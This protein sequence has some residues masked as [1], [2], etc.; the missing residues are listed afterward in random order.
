MGWMRDETGLDKN[1]ANYVPLTPLSHLARAAKVFANREALVYGDLRLTYARY[2][3]RV[4][5]L[6]SALQMAGVAPGDVVATLLPNIPAQAEAHFGVPACGAVL[7]TINIRLDVDTIAYIF[8]HGEAKVVL[9]A[10]K[11]TGSMQ[12]AMDETERRR[13]RQVAHNEKHGIT[14][15]TI[16]RGI[17]DMVGD[18]EAAQKIKDERDS[19]TPSGLK[20]KG[21][22]G[23]MLEAA[24]GSE[25]FTG[26]KMGGNAIAVAA[27]LEKR[28]FQAAENL[29][30]EEA[31]RLRDELV[32]VRG[33]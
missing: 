14:P 3:A 2:H 21:K 11:I 19:Y 30:F 8:D 23:Q 4:S 1:P 18:S 26:Q 28:M 15:K 25:P 24:E 27:E 9:Y 13:T 33:A 17:A 7:N 32:K 20:K 6:A 22:R 10:D 31:A 16:L 5:Q 29:E 12:R